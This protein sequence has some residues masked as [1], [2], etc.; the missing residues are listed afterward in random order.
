MCGT[1]FL[2]LKIIRP[3]YANISLGDICILDWLSVLSLFTCNKT[4][5]CVNSAFQALSLT[6]I[7]R[8]R[9]ALGIYCTTAHVD[10]PNK[11]DYKDSN[12]PK[13]RKYHE[14]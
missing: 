14:C 11:T 12:V 1:Y 13:R 8:V 9:N 6:Y 10:Y 4:R 2:E 5:Q 3:V 7:H